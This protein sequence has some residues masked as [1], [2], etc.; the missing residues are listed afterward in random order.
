MIASNLHKSIVRLCIC[1]IAVA[2]FS[3]PQALAL[4]LRSPLDVDRL[5]DGSTLITD[6]PSHPDKES[7]ILRIGPDGEVLWVFDEGINFAHNADLQ[8]NGNM[9]I[10][11]TGHDRVIEVD[12]DF[13][14]VWNTDDLAFSDGSHLN[15]PND[16]NILEGDTILITDRDNHRVF[17]TDRFG[18]ILWQFGVT[19]IPSSDDTHLNDPHNADRLD[20]GNTILADSNNSRVIEISPS[21]QI[22]WRY[23]SGFGWP[24]DADRLDSGNT[25]I[26]DVR[27]HCI[28][29]VDPAGETVWQYDFEGVR[30]FPYDADRLANGN[31]LTGDVIHRR[32]IEVTPDKEI[33][34]EYPCRD[35]F[36]I[37]L[38]AF[39]WEGIL[40]FR[41]TISA[42]EPATWA[43]CLIV[44]FPEV[45]IIPL[46]TVPLPVITPP[47]DLPTLTIPFPSLGWI[48]IWSGLFTA[49]GVQAD[50]FE[51]VDTGS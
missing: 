28:F 4:E 37:E 27:N 14:I 26:T 20:N 6:S 31:T 19:G 51:W 18:N 3:A 30:N 46:W 16:A 38:D 11:D 12:A 47:V 33:V 9:I 25:L 5:A 36:R 29:E 44:P 41:F 40:R 8:D 13:N 39:Y 21:G 23:Q 24:R 42:L 50:D 7:R 35:C 34:W 15:Y 1:F 10:S 22:V 43:N 32:V 48:G 49:E 45:Q 2:I 17:E